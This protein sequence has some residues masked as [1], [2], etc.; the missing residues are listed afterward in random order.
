MVQD[1]RQI[2]RSILIEELA[3]HGVQSAGHG[4]HRGPGV[5][6][7]FV[8]IQSDRE[9]AR[10]AE[11]L[12]HMAR[13]SRSRADIESGRLV[14]RLERPVRNEHSHDR[15]KDTRLPAGGRTQRFERGLITESQVHQ[16]PDDI[17]V[18]SLGK[19]AVLTPLAKDAIRHA[20]I[21]IERVK[22]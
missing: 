21:K 3:D 17:K 22:T 20:G 7:E 5:R 9:L 16:L 10:F 1:L 6:Q 19:N 2:I 8:S 12:L 18:V 4:G 14:F 11:R 15:Y 13:D